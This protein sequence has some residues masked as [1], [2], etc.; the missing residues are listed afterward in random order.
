MRP[1]APF[2][3]LSVVLAAVFLAGCESRKEAPALRP[4]AVGVALAGKMD[5]PLAVRG[6]GHVVAQRT[7]SVQ[8][9]VTGKL[10]ALHFAEGASVREGQLLATIDPQS[11][12]ARLDEARG[13][14]GRDWAKA[15]QASREY[16]RY[17]D[18]IRQ[19]VV[20]QDDF[21]QRKADFDAAWQ[22][23]KADQA[24]LESARI[25]LGYCRISSPVNGVA[26]YQQVKP[27][28]IVSANTTTLCTLN[29][30]QPVLVRFSVTEADLAV[31]RR[32]YGVSP[33]RVSAR[34]PKEEQDLKEF[35]LLT[36]IDNVVDVQTGMISLQAQFANEELALWPGQFVNVTATLD[37]DK[38]QTVVPYD[39][40][41]TRQDGAFVYVVTDKSTAELRRVKPGRMVYKT[42]VVILEGLSPGE[43]VISEGVVRVAPGGAVSVSR[44]DQGPDRAAG[45]AQGAGGGAGK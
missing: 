36:A 10:L 30:I 14:L 31:V 32:Y 33:V 5:A 40:L 41:M 1:V 2:V 3:V 24:A 35:G 13:A 37:V 22:Q 19:Q 45:Q 26:G 8:P 28:N 17:K 18:L 39:A 20:S 7:V 9:Q 34:V 38:D 29:Q 12:Q 25:D 11:F 44:S 21:D 15:E 42:H 23:V 4:M 16:L 43:T 27:G 6:V